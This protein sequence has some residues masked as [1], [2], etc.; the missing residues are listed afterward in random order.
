M[1]RSAPYSIYDMTIIKIAAAVIVCSVAVLIL[2]RT[3]PE[4]SLIVQLAGIAAVALMIVQSVSALS[5]GA[6]ELLDG[7]V[8]DGYIRLLLKALGTALAAKTGSD[9][10]NDSGNTALAG[11]VELAGKVLVIMMC[12]S[13]LRT[14][15]SFAGGMLK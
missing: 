7:A 4:T 11:V 10:C 15:V 8:E 6:Q 2:R 12:M 14:V 3:V 9:I 5:K 13:M 1:N